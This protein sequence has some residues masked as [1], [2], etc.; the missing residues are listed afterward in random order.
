MKNKKIQKMYEGEKV[1]GEKGYEYQ[2]DFLKTSKNYSKGCQLE[3]TTLEK[4]MPTRVHHNRKRNA[5][6]SKNTQILTKQ[7]GKRKKVGLEL[8]LRELKMSHQNWISYVCG[9]PQK[10][11]LVAFAI[12]CVNRCWHPTS[13][14]LSCC[15]ECSTRRL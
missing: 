9:W 7:D 14:C 8:L 10:E 4:G 2:L 15:L 5:N 13:V 6:Y 3:F 1:W 12:P 11:R